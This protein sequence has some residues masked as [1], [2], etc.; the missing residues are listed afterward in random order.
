M[1]GDTASISLSACRNRVVKYCMH[2]AVSEGCRCSP[3]L[4]KLRQ[5]RTQLSD[6]R[7]SYASLPQLRRT[8]ALFLAKL[9]F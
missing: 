3:C 5:L 2:V 9:D 8:L 4:Q 6:D 7:E 1:A